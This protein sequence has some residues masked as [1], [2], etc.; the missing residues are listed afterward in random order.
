MLTCFVLLKRENRTIHLETLLPSCSDVRASVLIVT[1]QPQGNAI[2]LGSNAYHC[3]ADLITIQVQSLPN[4]GE[5]SVE[6]PFIATSRLGI[7]LG[8]GQNKLSTLFV[9]GIFPHGYHALSKDVVIGVD[10]ELRGWFEI[11]EHS[12]KVLY[13]VEG[14]TI[15]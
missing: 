10:R 14:P 12:P 2:L 13:R 8:H 6:P 7:L 9:D 11:V 4:N 5:Y 15:R 3:P 1:S